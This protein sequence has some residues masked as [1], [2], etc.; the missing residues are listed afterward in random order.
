MTGRGW[1]GWRFKERTPLWFTAIVTLLLVD[2]VLHFG[3]LF[4]VSSWAQSS[5]DTVHTYRIPFRDGV[6][7]FV[8]FW[9]GRYL[10]TW[11]IGVGLLALLVLLLF[12]NRD[13]LEREASG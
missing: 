12:L 8:P 3:L 13:R 10:D 7:Y 1:L 5:R 2:S 9:L 6:N 4:T 11:W